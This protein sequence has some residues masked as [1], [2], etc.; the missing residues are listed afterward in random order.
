MYESH[1]REIS[2]RVLLA[3]SAKLVGWIAFLARNSLALIE[4]N[5]DTTKG[6]AHRKLDAPR[7][8][9]MFSLNAVLLTEGPFFEA[10]QSDRNY[11]LSLDADRFL[12]YFRTTTG[13]AA[14]R[15]PYGGWE[16]KVGRMLGHYL[17][18]CSMFGC[19]KD[20]SALIE[21]RRYI[22]SELAECQRANGNGYVGGVVDPTRV[23]GAM[24]KVEGYGS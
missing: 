3:Q 15:E 22:V 12:H 16:E 6:H 19:A 9:Q 13:L 1:E 11:L 23:D 7:R 2:R 24:A 17:S 10:M 14:K 5:Q 8:A 20:D 21:R 4:Q 18:A